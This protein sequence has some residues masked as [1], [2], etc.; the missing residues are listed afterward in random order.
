MEQKIKRK[1]VTKKL[2][3]LYVWILVGTG[4]GSQVILYLLN[5]YTKL[6]LGAFMWI[7]G[8]LTGAGLGLS[9]S[10]TIK[11]EGFD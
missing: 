10:R 8:L 1:K 9:N 11:I 3:K 2:F 6:D 5:L 4:L 7:S